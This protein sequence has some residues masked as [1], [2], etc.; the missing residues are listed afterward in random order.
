ML[1]YHPN[2]KNDLNIQ[3]LVKETWQVSEPGNILT[4]TCNKINLPQLYSQ[5]KDPGFI[6]LSVMMMILFPVCDS[7]LPVFQSTVQHT[8]HRTQ[9][10]VAEGG[11]WCHPG[12]TCVCEPG[13]ARRSSTE[14]LSDWL[15]A[16]WAG[17]SLPPNTRCRCPGS[18]HEVWSGSRRSAVWSPQTIPD[19]EGRAETDNG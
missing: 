3:T 4:N 16:V 12:S 9:V 8:Q 18:H 2:G 5:G 11:D 15:T 17:R 10:A 19:P 6:L 13:V 7:K 14:L 1:A